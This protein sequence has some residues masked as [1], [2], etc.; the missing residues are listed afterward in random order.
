MAVSTNRFVAHFDML[1]T[2]SLVRR[3][4]DI[5]WQKLSDLART[6]KEKLTQLG[7]QR[8]DTGEMIEDRVHYFIFSDT[9]VAYTGKDDENDALCIQILATELFIGALSLCIPLRGG[10]AYGRFDFNADLHL[11]SGPALVDAYEMGESCQ[12]LGIVL[13]CQTA[14]AFTE[15]TTGHS[16]SGEKV[17]VPYHVPCGKDGEL[18]KHMVINWVASHHGNFKGS[19]PLT[20]EAFY[21]PFEKL[22]GPLERLPKRVVTKYENTV[23][24]FNRHY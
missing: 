1:G 21:A 14:Q 3:D 24:F 17:V 2:K 12:W 4:A 16:T 19:A 10:I 20:L 8:V 18:H 13:D 6:A 11:F 5:A 15:L 9:I 7:I 23:A 22:F